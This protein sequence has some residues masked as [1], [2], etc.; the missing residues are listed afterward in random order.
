M[1]DS[2]ISTR[3]VTE[4][5]GNMA[6]FRWRLPRKAKLNSLWVTVWL[7]LPLLLVK[8]GGPGLVSESSETELAIVGH[9]AWLQC[10]PGAGHPAFQMDYWVFS[11]S[12]PTTDCQLS[13]V[14]VNWTILWGEMNVLSRSKQQYM[15]AFHQHVV[16][17]SQVKKVT[18]TSDVLFSVWKKRQWDL[19][20]GG[21]HPVS[22]VHSSSLH[23][24][25]RQAQLS[26]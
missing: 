8:A 24:W 6:S 1:K 14:S 4:G 12:K 9:Q 22:R 17:T 13:G 21:T 25:P 15:Q 16:K 11:A 19:A 3:L 18:R 5:T 20:G 23:G 26:V 10:G 7:P 2:V